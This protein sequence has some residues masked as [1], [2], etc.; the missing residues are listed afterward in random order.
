MGHP[1][2]T[3]E[4]QPP[5]NRQENKGQTSAKR[6]KLRFWK[7]SKQAVES[8][9][10]GNTDSLSPVFWPYAFLREDL[11]SARIFTYGYNADVV[12]GLFQ[13]SNQNSIFEHTKT[14]AARLDR[15]LEETDAPLIF[16]VHSLGGIIVK[17]AIGQSEM[18]RQRTKLV[19]FFGTPHRGSPQ[20]SWG[21]LASNF[22][23]YFLLLD[24]N[25]NIV[26][27]LDQNSQTLERIHTRFIDIVLKNNIMIH[28]FQES[29]EIVSLRGKVVEGDS[30]YLGIGDRET[31][32]T[33]DADHRTMTKF[34]KRSD[35]GYRAV[36]GVLKS[37]IRK[38]LQ[39]VQVAGQA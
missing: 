31:V 17:D 22:A 3:W 9:D 32:E 4:G 29:R 23:T 37:F 11:P 16:V 35:E 20:V 27:D 36:S 7:R 25:S 34:H 10:G 33:I 5:S 38:H 26:V 6:H 30:S 39:E 21:K 15:E 2:K 12:A 19:V 8:D 28:S 18:L 1:Q 13:A 24:T 14:M